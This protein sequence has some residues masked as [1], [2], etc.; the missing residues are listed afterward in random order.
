[1]TQHEPFISF[2][3]LLDDNAKALLNASG[4]D[5][6]QKIGM[7]TVRTVVLDVLSGR[8]LRDSTEML[9]RRRLAALNAATV[10]MMLRG[11][12]SQPD[13]VEKLPE[14]A[15]R[16]LRQKRLSRSEKWMAQWVLGLTDKASQNVLRDD[17][18]LLTEYRLRYEAVYQEVITQSVENYGP[19]QAKIFLNNEFVADL[20]WAFMLYLLG[21]VGAQTLAIRGSE[22]SLY[23][24]L[25]ERL[26]LGSLLAVLGFQHTGT[27]GAVGF[28]RE[29]WLSSQ[30]DRRESD[31]TAL[32]E[33]GKGVRF[34]IGFIGR[35]NPEISL[36]KVTR[37][38]WEISLGRST[39]YL[40]TIII[41]D[42][43]GAGS[44]I[45]E[46]ARRVEGDIVQM[47]LAYWPQEVAQI[48]HQR[49]GFVHPLVTMP[50]SDIHLYLAEAMKTVPLES[51][52]I[53]S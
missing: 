23:G 11:A 47:S 3:H 48:L 50:R 20:G 22:K 16:M 33:A 37:F 42:R 51:F 14:I 38:E 6:I 44:R 12:A 45:K 8:N 53:S 43:I 31:A 24:K 17:A 36:D 13:F 39:W 28:Q 18:E 32:W 40:A 26:V 5:L 4:N 10:A 27:S 2:L 30:E 7:E 29:F 49:M 52:L 34:D 19:L 21:A 1:M 35:G 25:F 9:T 41:V 15:E 46:L